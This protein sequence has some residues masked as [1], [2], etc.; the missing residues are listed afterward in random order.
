MLSFSL[1]YKW[2]VYILLTFIYW[3]YLW[4]FS[5]PILVIIVLG[6]LEETMDNFSMIWEYV[7]CKNVNIGYVDV[8]CVLEIGMSRMVP[9]YCKCSMFV[10]NG[11]QYFLRSSLWPYFFFSLF[12]KEWSLSKFGNNLI[13]QI[14]KQLPKLIQCFQYDTW[15]KTSTY[16]CLYY[17]RYVPIDCKMLT[18]LKSVIHF[19]GHVYQSQNN[20]YIPFH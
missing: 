3:W 16:E 15:T 13:G 12:H 2:D 6:I 18:W 20:C 17:S 8:R 1:V 5:I 14:H 11:K 19:L 4:Q 9:K 10:W 7:F